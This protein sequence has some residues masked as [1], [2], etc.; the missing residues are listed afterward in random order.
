MQLV[1]L[2]KEFKKK[3]FSILFLFSFAFRVLDYIITN[4]VV[5]KI[6]FFFAQCTYIHV[7]GVP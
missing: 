4:T 6:T 2:I 3:K 5:T 7:K 1:C